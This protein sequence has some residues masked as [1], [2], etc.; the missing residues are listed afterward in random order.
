LEKLRQT[1]ANAQQQASEDN[2]STQAK[3]AN[4]I[5]A[6]QR[7]KMEIEKETIFIPIRK[8]LVEKYGEQAISLIMSKKVIDMLL[9]KTSTLSQLKAYQKQLIMETAASLSIDLTNYDVIAK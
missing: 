8:V 6:A 7:Q 3:T 4:R 5:S 2:L 1:I 9:E